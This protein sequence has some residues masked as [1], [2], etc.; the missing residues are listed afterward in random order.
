MH[1]TRL[2]LHSSAKFSQMPF[3]SALLTGTKTATVSHFCQEGKYTA[4]ASQESN[5]PVVAWEIIKLSGHIVLLDPP[6]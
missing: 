5:K 6:R 1:L 3:V 2:R 4:A